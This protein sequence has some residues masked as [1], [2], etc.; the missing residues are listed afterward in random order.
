VDQLV[1]IAGG[2]G[3]VG[4]RLAAHLARA[5]PGRVVVAGRS[6]ER[7][8][9]A[10]QVLGNGAS[11]RA[12]DVNDAVSVER[13][14]D[15]VATVMCCVE[16]AAPYALLSAAAARGIAYTD[17]TA[18][19]IWRA[20]LALRAE[21]EVRGARIVLGAGLVPGVSSA[22]ACAAADRLGRLESVATSLLLSAGDVF[23]PDS[24]E[25]LLRELAAPLVVTES[26]RERIVACFSEPRVVEFP[27]PF[28][29]RSAWRAPF[30]DQYFFARSL[31]VAT[32]TTRLALDPPWMGVVI[33]ALL[34]GGARRLLQ[35][36]G[37]RKLVHRAVSAVHGLRE[38]SDRW[39]LVVHAG[40]QRGAARFSLVGRGQAEATAIAASVLV[41]MLCDRAIE[42]PG[43]W[44]AEQVVDSERFFA[45]LREAGLDVTAAVTM[46]AAQR[47]PNRG[48]PRARDDL[49]AG[50]H[51]GG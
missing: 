2:Y 21:A 48:L 26:G 39:A 10:A 42:R 9:H 16:Q 7:A 1:L 14:L 23:G 13:A 31:G 28:G 45:G 22:M 40:G 24:L 12:V 19:S 29:R 34:R 11:A 47:E 32:A 27:V 4:R 51:D 18:S 41:R 3:E 33:A 43:V 30:A 36:E 8:R 46:S 49:F 5:S 25:Y 35:R 37:F 15:G 6:L 17:L 50:Q 44:F 38:G 20:A